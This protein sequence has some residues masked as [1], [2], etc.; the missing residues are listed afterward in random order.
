M[1]KRIQLPFKLL[2]LP[3]LLSRYIVIG[4]YGIMDPASALSV[5]GN[6][7][8]FL[9]FSQK[10]ISKAI[11]VYKA[12]DGA[13][14]NN[15]ETEALVKD[16]VLL[17]MRFTTNAQGTRVATGEAELDV[18]GVDTV[19][20]YLIG[21]D[22]VLRKSPAATTLERDPMREIA[23]SCGHIANELLLRLE[24]LKTGGKSRFWKSLK[25]AL[26]SLWTESELQ[27]LK[28]RLAANKEMLE[29][30]VLVSLR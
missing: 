2:S 22:T 4:L 1:R 30:H 29:W 13:S 12:A 9:E 7:L 18:N 3:L 14:K 21:H 26:K 17:N 28:R 25:A 6:V 24:S 23:E 5:A 27:D 16:F 19:A 8:Q 20:K 10:F 11:D 15:R